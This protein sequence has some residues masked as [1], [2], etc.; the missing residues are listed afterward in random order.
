MVFKRFLGK[1]TLLLA[2]MV[3]LMGALL[4]ACGS[5]EESDSGDGE[6][7]TPTA[8]EASGGGEATASATEAMQELSG[9]LNIEGSSTV[10][11]YTRLAIEA[12]EA[13]HPDV[14]VTTGEIGSGGGITAFINKE[15]PIAAASRQIKQEEIDQAKAAGLDPFETTIFRDAL[16][17]VV[18]PSN[19]AVESLTFEQVAKIFAGE[20]TNW[21]E[22]G[23]NDADIVLYTR[24]EESGTFA[25]LEE[26]VIQKAL[27]KEAEYSA[28]IN[29]QA[30]APAGLTAVA[31]D[32]NGIFYAGLGNL[33]DIPAGAVRVIPIAKDDSSEAFEPSEA[34]VA[35]G[36][37]PI[38]RGLFY[39]TDGDPAQSSDPLVKAYIEFVL[40]PEGQ[41]IGEEIGFLPVN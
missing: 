22:V 38:A 29:K 23:G 34:T 16:A 39:Y 26:D 27:G 1:R 33:S 31:G 37:Y 14:T 11:P 18:H 10:A 17:I 41:A 3:G 25:Y 35:S 8:T 9:S 13:A 21:S 36:D 32:P 28:D 20:I 4:V 40:S 2:L 30:N 5:D 7:T 12:F 15:V 6:A 19:T 24:N